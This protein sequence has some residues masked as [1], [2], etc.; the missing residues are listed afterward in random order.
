MDVVER[1]QLAGNSS[2]TRA[3]EVGRIGVKQFLAWLTLRDVRE[4]AQRIK[5]PIV[6]GQALSEI[7]QELTVASNLWHA[8]LQTAAVQCFAKALDQ[9]SALCARWPTETKALQQTILRLNTSE[10]QPTRWTPSLTWVVASVESC[11]SLDVACFAL[12]NAMAPLR[13]AVAPRTHL[14]AL[15][16]LRSLAVLAMVLAVVGGL[17]FLWRPQVT[18]RAS[19]EYSP[20]YPARY[21]LDDRLSTNWLLPDATSG[22]IELTIPD[23]SVRVAYL[24][25]VQGMEAYGTKTCLLELF[26]GDTPVHQTT[27]N[28]ES[29]L[30]VATPYTWRPT[31]PIRANRLRITPL[32][33]VTLG[34]GLS[35]VRVHP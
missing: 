13:L 30:G 5:D 34:A 11:S 21:V 9:L 19:H 18:A 28:I 22:W 26:D 4:L 2:H 27:L 6:L 35:Q 23:H 1:T 3:T 17:V 25:N 24:W 15:R 29:T 14:R 33:W 12:Q 16:V 10:P 31:A 32:T 20:I 8:S 7:D